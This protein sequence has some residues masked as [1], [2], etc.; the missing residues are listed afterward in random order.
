MTKIQ[1]LVGKL[2]D[3]YRTKSIM[4]D[5]SRKEHPTCSAKLQRRTVKE[6]GNIELFELGEISK[7]VQCPTCLRYSK[8]RPVYCLCCFV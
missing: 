2:Q 7:T 6:M 1:R 5:W 3:G 4:D 8:E